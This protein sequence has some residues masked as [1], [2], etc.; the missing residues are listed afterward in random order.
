MVMMVRRYF[1]SDNASRGQWMDERE[2]ETSQTRKGR[3][4]IYMIEQTEYV[5]AY[6]EGALVFQ[7]DDAVEAVD[8]FV[9]VLHAQAAL[10]PAQRREGGHL[11]ERR[12][13]CL[14]RLEIGLPVPVMYNL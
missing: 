14:A 13:Q 8:C 12:R 7:G 2:R 10:Q 11:F 5:H 9:G 6:A 3:K 4:N 1:V